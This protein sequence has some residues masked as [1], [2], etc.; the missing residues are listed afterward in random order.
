MIAKAQDSTPVIVQNQ[1]GVRIKGKDVRVASIRIQDRVVITTGGWLKTALVRDEAF[2]QGEIAPH[3]EEFIAG[4]KKW[5]AKPDLFA[6]PQKISEPKRDFPY[7]TE[8]DDFAVI[9]VTTYEDWLKKIKKDVKEN[10]RRAKREGVEARTSPY[11]DKFVQG[12]KTLYDETPVRQGKRFWHYGK[13]FDALKEL[14]GTYG[15]RAEYIGAYLGEELIGFVK[16][17][18]VDNFAKTMHV[19]SGERHWQKRP[20]NLLIAK[21]VEVCAARRLEAFIYGEYNFPGK[22][23]NSLTEFKSRNGF[24]EVRYP[25]YFV[26][27]TAKGSLLL[28]F[29]LHRGLRRHFPP[30]VTNVLLKLRSAYYRRKFAAQLTGRS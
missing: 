10:L 20:T 1:A 29:G 2:V 14:H 19:I 5:G 6:F 18:Y 26:P 11:D 27:L 15:E 12:I 17:V 22:K 8:W 25:R 21:A 3:P 28:R 9:R 30:S 13:S 23:E 24:E 7:H 16:M 4:L